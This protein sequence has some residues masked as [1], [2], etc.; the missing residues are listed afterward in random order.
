MTRPKNKHES[1][2]QELIAAA[3]QRN[4]EVRME[5]L[6]REVGYRTH[7]GRCRIKNRQMI[8]IDR[9]APLADQIEFLAAELAQ[10]NPGN[11]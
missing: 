7:S 8:F 1:K 2:L 3:R 6:L 9:D 11:N 5:K 10:E 4:I